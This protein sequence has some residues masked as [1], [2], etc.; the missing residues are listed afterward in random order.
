MAPT[1][2][3]GTDSFERWHERQLFQSFAWLTTCILSGVV[4]AAILEFIG[5]RTPGIMRLATLVVLY[6]V[7]LMGLIAWRR[8][9][10]MLS[11]AQNCANG[12]TCAQ[13]GA[14]GLFDVTVDSGSIPA[15][16]RRC[17]HRWTIE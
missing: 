13:C 10:T 1:R 7:G 4:I 16:C 11:H 14:Y 5:L 12:A 2:P 9:R 15:R 3:A 8:F 6:F 17:G